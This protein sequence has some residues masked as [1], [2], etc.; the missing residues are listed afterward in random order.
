MQWLQSLP[1]ELT[2]VHTTQTVTVM[3]F[4][5]KRQERIPEQLLYDVSVML[6]NRQV[7]KTEQI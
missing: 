2:I 4:T 5:R 7:L 1:R 3:S 6:I